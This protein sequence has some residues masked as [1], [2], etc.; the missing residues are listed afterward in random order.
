MV[1]LKYSMKAS[2]LAFR[3]SLE[4]KLPRLSSL[5]VKMLSQIFDLIHPGGVLGRI[6]K[7]DPMGWIE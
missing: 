1:R 2:T 3:C 4:V 7:D 6:V 5:R